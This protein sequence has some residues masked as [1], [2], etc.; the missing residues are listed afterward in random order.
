VTSG[1]DLIMGYLL[2]TNS[3]YVVVSDRYLYQFQGYG[4]RYVA[5]FDG[6]RWLSR[7][8]TAVNLESKKL[9]NHAR[10][11]GLAG[12]EMRRYRRLSEEEACMLLYEVGIDV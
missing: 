1:F 5:F 7:R 12:D 10:Y 3:V 8:G 4:W 11:Y 6:D 9:L 2:A